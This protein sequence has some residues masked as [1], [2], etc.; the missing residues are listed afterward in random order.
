MAIKTLT[1]GPSE[2]SKDDEPEGASE[3]EILRDIRIDLGTANDVRLFR[4]SSGTLQ[5]HRGQYVRVGLAPGSG[6]LIGLKSV[7]VTPDMVG[8]RIAIFASIEVKKHNGRVGKKQEN[9]AR[10]VKSL[11]GIAG[12]VRSVEEAWAVLASYRR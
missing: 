4:N 12:V 9:W 1:T 5:T 3:A 11:G 7:V 6:D 10:M 2:S 8:Q